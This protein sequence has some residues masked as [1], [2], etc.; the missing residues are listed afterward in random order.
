MV[1][2]QIDM[3]RPP[4]PKAQAIGFAALDSRPAIRCLKKAQRPK[5][6]SWPF[7]SGV[8]SDIPMTT[9]RRTTLQPRAWPRTRWLN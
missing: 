2:K 7:D 4:W 8:D 1:D 6:R 9:L 5:I 3:L